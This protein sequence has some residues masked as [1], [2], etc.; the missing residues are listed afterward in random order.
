MN[1]DRKHSKTKNNKKKPRRMSRGFDAS[2]EIQTLFC[3]AHGVEETA[4]CVIDGNLEI[5]MATVCA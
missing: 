1:A 3:I 4:H 5:P 2:V